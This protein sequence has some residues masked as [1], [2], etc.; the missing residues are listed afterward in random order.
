MAD[1]VSSWKILWALRSFRCVPFAVFLVLF[2]VFFDLEERGVFGICVSGTVRKEL[3][4]LQLL[5]SESLDPSSPSFLF[6]DTSGSGPS[7]SESS[8]Q[9][10]YESHLSDSELAEES[11][12][13]DDSES[14]SPS[15]SPPGAFIG[16]VEGVFSRLLVGL[17]VV[18]GGFADGVFVGG[19][20]G[21]DQGK[22]V[23]YTLFPKTDLSV[24]I[25]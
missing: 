15:S 2:R 16:A 24:S 25:L 19:I 8:L 17:E 10:S 14:Q 3:R 4:G 6:L 7:S 22:S 21:A 5:S 20:G 23:W 18:G 12:L 1:L 13:L 9:S 11:P